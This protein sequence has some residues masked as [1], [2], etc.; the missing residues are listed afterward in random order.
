M[1]FSNPYNSFPNT[2][3]PNF[4][5]K[6]IED[7]FLSIFPGMKRPFKASAK[8]DP[9]E[10]LD[11][12]TL[13]STSKEDPIERKANVKNEIYRK[14]KEEN[15]RL[16]AERTDLLFKV[17][18]LEQKLRETEQAMKPL[19]LKAVQENE[20]LREQLVAF[21]SF[22]Q[23]LRS[24][25]RGTPSTTGL[26]RELVTGAATD[27]AAMVDSLMS[28]SV[29]Q[30]WV[31][32]RINSN[33]FTFLQPEDN[34]RVLF[35]KKSAGNN[36]QIRIELALPN[37]NAAD[38]AA[39]YFKLW[40][41]ANIYTQV[42]GIDYPSPR[43]VNRVACNR[44][45]LTDEDV[46]VFGAWI[47]ES[48]PKPYNTTVWDHVIIQKR[49]KA[50]LS[51]L[52]LPKE[53]SPNAGLAAPK[54][55]IAIQTRNGRK[56]ADRKLRNR[57]VQEEYQ[58]FGVVDAH[59]L[60]RSTCLHT[61]SLRQNASEHIGITKNNKV[62]DIEA[63]LTEGIVCWDEHTTAGK[64]ARLSIVIDAPQDV[65]FLAMPGVNSIVSANGALTRYYSKI[66][67]RYFGLV[68]LS[69][70]YTLHDYCFFC[71]EN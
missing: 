51:T 65:G 45:E 23:Q 26:F 62:K 5:Q 44:N 17:E 39:A 6:K 41:E 15:K 38:I 16:R 58:S 50:V 52:L 69:K 31:P 4:F 34:L 27:A 32:S 35:N 13:F 63:A 37:R 46:N 66:I 53:K 14:E 24:L 57:L 49:R 12:E 25:K 10:D 30:E 18:K 67:D 55:V 48:P 54:R 71:G 8:L 64:T 68:E 11:T 1:Y 28:Q 36:K 47:M 60:A 20:L 22:F 42:F 2:P 70:A 9:L 19:T 56:L 29:R 3:E 40:S 7:P 43:G 59:I 33:W 61:K 21:E